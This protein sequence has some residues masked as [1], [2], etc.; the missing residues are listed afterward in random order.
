VGK[1]SIHALAMDGT[2][3]QGK[4]GH[5]IYTVRVLINTFDEGI[6]SNLHAGWLKY[7]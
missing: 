6:K 4:F 2:H 3:Y 7:P 1:K 5:Q